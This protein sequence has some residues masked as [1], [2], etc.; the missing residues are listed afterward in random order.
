MARKAHAAEP[1]ARPR[2]R[3]GLGLAIASVAVVLAAGTVAVGFATRPH[4]TPPSFEKAFP[5]KTAVAVRLAPST[6]HWGTVNSLVARLQLPSDWSALPKGVDALGV[7]IAPSSTPQQ[8]RAVYLEA[9]SPSRAKAIDAYLRKADGA[10]VRATSTHGRAVFI[11]DMSDEGLASASTFAKGAASQSARL[12]DDLAAADSPN[13]MWI[14]FDGLNTVMRASASEEHATAAA[15]YMRR[16]LGIAQGTTWTGKPSESG[17]WGGSF[18]RGGMDEGLLDP[19]AAANAAKLTD[20][21]KG[22]IARIVSATTASYRTSKKAINDI[23]LGSV[24]DLGDW[25]A[26]MPKRMPITAQLAPSGWLAAA[27]GETEAGEGIA[28]INLAISK[29]TLAL[30][31]DENNQERRD[32]IE[33]E[34]TEAP[35]APDVPALPAP[36]ADE[37]APGDFNPVT[38]GDRDPAAEI[39]SDAPQPVVP[40]PTATATPSAPEKIDPSAPATSSGGTRQPQDVGSGDSYKN[41]IPDG[42]GSGG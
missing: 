22:S 17:Y 38:G 7:S 18:T 37:W 4:E 2:S 30:S 41:P 16:T 42:F 21:K 1:P 24:G 19:G 36:T 33:P 10:G 8:G 27:S 20:G 12:R 13:A 15:S 11:T 29:N 28:A 26:S 40:S 32:V 35:A 6:T 14:D 31:F 25:P 34:G 3:W 39:G 9:T 5:A 23:T